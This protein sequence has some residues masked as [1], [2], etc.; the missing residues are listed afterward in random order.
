MEEC[1]GQYNSFQLI[2]PHGDPEERLVPIYNYWEQDDLPEEA[3]RRC[4]FLPCTP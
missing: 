2:D 4:A 1:G 3:V